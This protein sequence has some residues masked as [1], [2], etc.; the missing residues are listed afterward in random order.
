MEQYHIGITDYNEINSRELVLGIGGAG[1]N[2]IT[3]ASYLYIA[4]NPETA[5]MEVKSQFGDLISLP[6]FRI[7]KPLYVID[8]GTEK[9]FQMSDTELYGMSMGDFFTLLMLRFAEP[10]RGENAYRVTQIM[11]DYLRKTGIDGIKYKSFLSPGGFNY[12]IFNC[13]PS[14]IEFCK[15]KVVL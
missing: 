4:S 14:A 10:V 3:G 1:R 6:K 15:S 7:V 11:A 9:T 13:H 5:C 8:F 2:N 12:I